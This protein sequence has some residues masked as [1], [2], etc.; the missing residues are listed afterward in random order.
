MEK[1]PLQKVISAVR[2]SWDADTSSVKDEWTP[3]NPA[4][5]QCVPSSL[6]IQ[7]FQGGDIARVI[8]IGEGVSE[9]HYYNEISSTDDLDLT[10]SQYRRQVVMVPNPADLKAENVSTTREY[11]MKNPKTL[12]RYVLLKSRVAELLAE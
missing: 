6:V 3:E 2:A 7:D 4:R 12:A 5:G 9:S 8:V 10:G 1:P 11:L